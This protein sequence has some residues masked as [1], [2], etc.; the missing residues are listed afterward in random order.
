[1]NLQ[2]IWNQDMWPAWG[3]RYT[4]NINTQMNYWPAEVCNLSECHLPL[5]D[6]SSGC[7]RPV[8]KRRRRCTAAWFC[9][10]PQHRHLGRHRSAGSVD[11]ATIWP[12]GAAWL[13]LHI[14][15]HYEFTQDL[16]FLDQHYEA[17]REG[18]SVFVDYL[19]ENENG[20]W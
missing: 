5:F 14:F 17:M 10:P 16:A 18:C 7:A 8:T 2:G 6:S 1:M 15:E 12:M 11:A 3:C 4:I 20:D 13:C 9:L 19:I